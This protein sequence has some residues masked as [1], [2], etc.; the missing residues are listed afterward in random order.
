MLQAG[1]SSFNM[2]TRG[3]LGLISR[4]G[5]R[6]NAAYNHYDS[7]PSGLG[8]LIVKFILKLKPEEWDEMAKKVEDIEV[9]QSFMYILFSINSPHSSPLPFATTYPASVYFFSYIFQK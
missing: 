7:Y 3:L 4:R 6:R 8:A 1:L 2:G 9:C 5:T